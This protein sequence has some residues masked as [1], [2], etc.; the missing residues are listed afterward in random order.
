MRSVTTGRLTQTLNKYSQGLFL[1]TQA[2]S[3][4]SCSMEVSEFAIFIERHAGQIIKSISVSLIRRGVTAVLACGGKILNKALQV[5]RDK[6]VCHRNLFA[7]C[8]SLKVRIK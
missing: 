6:A 7:G 1:G 3:L 8:F 4:S 5:M 2:G